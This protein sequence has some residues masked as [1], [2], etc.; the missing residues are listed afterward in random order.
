MISCFNIKGH[1]RTHPALTMND[2]RCPSQLF[3]S[4]QYAPSKENGPLAIVGIFFPGFVC[5]HL[6]LREIV[7]I[8]NE[9]NLYS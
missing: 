1:N 5:S 4:F 2:V 8:V 7:I 3:H 9:I 6:T